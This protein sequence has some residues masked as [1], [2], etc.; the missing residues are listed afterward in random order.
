M[1]L[2]RL[3]AAA[4]RTS[5]AKPPRRRL[6][7]DQKGAKG[8]GVPTTI[9][10]KSESVARIH[11]PATNGGGGGACWPRLAMLRCCPSFPLL[12]FGSRMM[13]PL[14]SRST[15]CPSLHLAL[16][17]WCAAGGRVVVF[18]DG[19]VRCR[20]GIGTAANTFRRAR[21]TIVMFFASS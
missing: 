8:R 9:H 1:A 4:P 16:L 6:L 18:Q 14:R 19:P 13:K 2:H 10:A 7:R 11:I 21:S 15:V 12:Y 17:H 20:P 3:L 5:I